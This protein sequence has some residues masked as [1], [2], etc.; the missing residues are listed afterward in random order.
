MKMLLDSLNSYKQI[1]YSYETLLKKC[2]AFQAAKETSV[3][4]GSTFKYVDG[5]I[6]NYKIDQN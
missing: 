2:S 5:C 6:D 3:L 1:N 4:R